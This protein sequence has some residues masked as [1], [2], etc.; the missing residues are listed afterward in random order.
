MGLCRVGARWW[1]GMTTTTTWVECS[2]SFLP[3]GV[4]RQS[5]L[6]QL[7]RRP[8]G[9]AIPWS[10]DLFRRDSWKREFTSC[11]SVHWMRSER[12]RSPMQHTL[13][14]ATERNSIPNHCPQGRSHLTVRSLN[15][16]RFETR[17]TEMLPFKL[18]MH[19]DELDNWGTPEDIGATT[20][21]GPIKV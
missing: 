18:S 11:H 21:K 4:T 1:S 15:W 3:I 13:V 20:I 17:E 8:P 5:M 19:R 10:S 9:P 6:P 7:P 12:A 14:V 2:L 16:S